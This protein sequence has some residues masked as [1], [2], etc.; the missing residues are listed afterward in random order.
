MKFDSVFRIERYIEGTNQL[1]G[2]V[3]PTFF[4]IQFIPVK[5]NRDDLATIRSSQINCF[6]MKM[7]QKKQR[8]IYRKSKATD[9][10]K[11]PENVCKF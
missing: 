5:V 3:Y 11:I 2:R 8:Q 7:Q 4:K 1:F 6:R 9:P 10:R